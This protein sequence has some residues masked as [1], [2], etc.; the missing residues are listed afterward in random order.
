MRHYATI[1]AC[2]ALLCSSC[3]GREQEE[4]LVD[5]ERFKE[6][7]ADAYLLEA[8]RNQSMLVMDLSQ[9][10]LDEWYDELYQRHAV[11]EEMFRST[12][13][14][15][16]DRPGEMHDLLEDVLTILQKRKDMGALEA[17]PVQP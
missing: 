9:N 15:Y 1:W 10:A 6:M 7:L 14:H 11:P 8:R 2:I 4:V 16:A 12:Y 13:A 3:G 5:R 17:E